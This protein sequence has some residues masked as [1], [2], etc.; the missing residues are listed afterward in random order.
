MKQVS[1]I[2][3]SVV[4]LANNAFV[5]PTKKQQS[6]KRSGSSFMVMPPPPP[7]AKK[8]PRP[9]GL[10]LLSRAAA[11]RPIVSPDLVALH[12]CVHRI[13]E[14]RLEEEDTESVINELSVDQ[15][16]HIV[17]D[18][19]GDTDTALLHLPTKETKTF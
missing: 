11:S 9:R 7:C 8:L 10:E 5:L 15:C 19:F 1:L 17:D 16:E 13:P 18:I 6:L 12:G 14:L 4:D 2:I 3:E